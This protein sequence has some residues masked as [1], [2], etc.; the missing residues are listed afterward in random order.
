MTTVHGQFDVKLS[1]PIDVAPDF[2]VSGLTTCKFQL[3]ADRIILSPLCITPV[4]SYPDGDY[5]PPKLTEIRVLISREI[6]LREDNLILSREEEQTFE[7][8]LVEAT[9]RF[10]TI[11]KHKTNQWDLDVRHPV[12]AYNYAYS[13]KDVQ[14]PTLWPMEPGHMRM[15]EYHMGTII[16]HTS[17]L[18][19]ELTQDIWQ[20]VI[21][22]VSSPA[23]VQFHDELLHDAKTFRSQMRYDA[24]VLYAA[25]ASELMLEKACGT[26]LR[27]KGGLNDRQCDSI[28]SKL[29]IPQL[30][31]LIN[32]LDPSLPVKEKD[33]KKLFQLRN[34]I[35]HGSIKTVTYKESNEALGIAEQLKQNLEG[36]L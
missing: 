36:I 12:Y 10:V 4:T 1:I 3:D 27:R 9:I 20:E 24:E 7:K 32:E 22:E 18:Q 31:E 26:L 23:S 21:A 30:L 11:I 8:V 33:T 14:L 5:E 17:E 2:P 16:F 15:P 29:R 35:A 6:N 34:K 13:L 25:I 28:V 19:D